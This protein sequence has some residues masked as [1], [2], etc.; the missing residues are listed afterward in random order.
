MRFIPKVATCC[1]SILRSAASAGSV[2]CWERGDIQFGSLLS[3]VKAIK[4]FSNFGDAPPHY[5][6]VYRTIMLSVFCHNITASYHNFSRDVAQ[7]EPRLVPISKALY[8]T[9]FICGQRCKWWSHRPKLTS[10][11]ISDVKAIIYICIYNW[12]EHSMLLF[13]AMSDIDL[14]SVTKSSQIGCPVHYSEQLIAKVGT[15][16]ITLNVGTLSYRRGRRF[17]LGCYM[18]YSKE[19]EAESQMIISDG[20][21]HSSKIAQ[22]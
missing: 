18:P 2:V 15:R 10:S 21:I 12:S 17:L 5:I 13:R 1:T 22:R 7:F 3:A 19:L 6:Q 4:K 11:V 8:H 16:M 14:V 20:S 9:C